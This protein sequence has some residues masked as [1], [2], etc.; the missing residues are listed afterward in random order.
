MRIVV[1]SCLVLAFLPGIGIEH[2]AFAQLTL[3][4]E[5]GAIRLDGDDEHPLGRRRAPVDDPR[6]NVLSPAQW[7]QVDAAVA[8]GLKWLASEQQPD[9]SFPTMETGQPGVTSLCIMA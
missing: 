6:S 4:K 2:V 7:Q 1:S 9:G 5:A 3:D 8:R